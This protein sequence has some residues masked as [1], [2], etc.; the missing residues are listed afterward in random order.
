M[1]NTPE[2]MDGDWEDEVPLPEGNE[3]RLSDAVGRMFCHCGNEVKISCIWSNGTWKILY[4]CT[5]ILSGQETHGHIKEEVTSAVLD[6]LQD[7]DLRTRAMTVRPRQTEGSKTFGSLSVA[8][9]ENILL[10]P[11][12]ERMIDKCP[13][14]NM[15]VPMVVWQLSLTEMRFAYICTNCKLASDMRDVVACSESR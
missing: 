14:C 13:L 10:N 7:A 15:V 3:S 12:L 6:Q 8:Q 11:V 2:L 9:I 4:T 1:G 5:T